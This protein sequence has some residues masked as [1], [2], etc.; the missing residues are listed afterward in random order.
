MP[1]PY[2]DDLIRQI[3]R[4]E[5]ELATAQERVRQLEAAQDGPDWSQAPAWAQWWAMDT[6]GWHYW[7]SE[8]PELKENLG[9]WGRAAADECERAGR[10][11]LPDWTRTLRRRPQEAVQ[12]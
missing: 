6:D 1:H 4:L 8:Q 12:P 9:Y 10:N 11:V 7:Y 5:A 2:R 3:S